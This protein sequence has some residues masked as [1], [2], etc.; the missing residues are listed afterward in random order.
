MNAGAGEPTPLGVAIGPE[1]ANV[2]VYSAHA[3]AIEFCLFGEAGDAEIARVRLP[4]RSGDIHHGFIPGVKAGALYGLR[5]YGA[6]AP[7]DGQRFDPAKL[8]ADPYA[9]ALDRPFKL[10]GAMF[11]RAADSAAFMPKCVAGAPSSAA[12]GRLNIPWGQTILYE[13]N[14]RGF[15]R[16]HPDVPEAQRGTFAG[17][18]HP[19]VIDHLV[20]LGVTSVEIMPAHAFVDERH[21]PPLGLANAWGYNPIVLGAPDP[22]LAPG[23]WREV[24][25]TTDALHAAGLEAILDVVLN[26]SGESDEFGPTLSM[27]GLDNAAYYRLLPGDPA[28][29]VNDTGCGNCLAL[30]REPML[31]LSIE[32]LRRWMIIGGFDGFRFDLATSIGRRDS[33]FDP[34]APLF[35]AIKRDDVLGAAKLIAEPWDIGP[36]G[37]RL[38][39]F[40]EGW[41]EWNDRFRDAARRFWRGDPYVRGEIA[42][43]IAGS[44]DIFPHAPGPTNSVNFVVA[45]D[46]F[47]LADLVSYEQKHNEANGENNRD[48]SNDNHSWNEGVEGPSEDPA[49][50]AA[51]ARDMR[52]LLS[53]LF[54][55][56]GA[57]MLPM[58]AELGYSQD[59]NNNAYAQNNAISWIDWPKADAALIEYTQRL[60]AIRRDHPALSRDA[61]LSGEPFD[62]SGL[63]DVE[64]RDAEGPLRTAQQ[65]EEP[66]GRILVVVFAAPRPGGEI[67]RVAIVLNRGH[68]GAAVALPSPRQGMAWRVLLDSTSP[69]QDVAANT[70]LACPP[71]ATLILAESV[72]PQAR[73]PKAASDPAIV[74]KLANAAG[75]AKEWWAIDG[76]RTQVNRETKIALLAAFRLPASSDAVARESLG[77]LVE[78]RER[79]PL[80]FYLVA[81]EGEVPV[82][83]LRNDPASLGVGEVTLRYEDGR[84]TAIKPDAETRRLALSDGREIVERRLP[85]P[86]LPLGRHVLIAGETT[87]DLTIAP[88]KAYLPEIARRRAFG[89]SAQLY[90][91]RRVGDQG[92]GDFSTLARLGAAAGAAGAATLGVNPLHMLFAQN[93]ERASPYHPSDRRFLDPIH[94]DALDGASLPSDADFVERALEKAREIAEVST[95]QTIDYPRVWGLK[96]LLLE[97]R[98]AAFQKTRRAQPSDPLFA[99]YDRYVAAGGE[100]LRR[101]ACFQAII[102]G[103]SRGDWREWPRDLRDGAPAAM[104]VIADRL[105]DRVEYAMFLQW[106]ADRQFAGAAARAKAGGLRLG[107]YRDLAIGAAPDGAEAWAGA[108]ELADGVSIGAPPDPFSRDGQIWHLPA[109][110]PLASARDGWR[111]FAGLFA[112]NM[113]HAGL[114]RI[115]HAM[116]L[117]RLFLVPKGAKPA[118]GAYVVY[119][120]RD[121]IG[122]LALESQR[123]QCV[124]VGEDLGTVP[125]GFRDTLAAADVLGMRVVWFEYDKGAFR[126]PQTYPA[127]AVACV[128]THDLPTLAGWW[129]GADI[130]ER[131]ALN[132]IDANSEKRER[133]ARAEEKGALVAALV[134]AGLIA[135]PPEPDAPAPGAL[136]A[137]IHAFVASAPSLLALAQIDDLAGETIATNLPGTDKER[138]NWRRRLPGDI[139]ALFTSARARAIISALAS[140]RPQPDF[141]AR[142]SA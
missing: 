47:T 140:L 82:A 37:Y 31:R 68:D 80:P 1:G 74:D 2:A 111:G 63:A 133:K 62:A 77:R 24:R 103:P 23:G 65:W 30:D 40:P 88:R 100:V 64:W 71:R 58:G 54:V 115:D 123:R 117:T 18:A 21:L 57:P 42:T 32:S 9:F 107:L 4:A 128:S 29:Y 121:L 39:D 22:R 36:G 19:K 11:E 127:L 122:I 27:R 72:A 44:R 96:S 110:D 3:E 135:A 141:G 139:D 83:P 134:A 52:N 76:A 112:A 46:G 84:E 113:R 35:A 41:S 91:Q 8:L 16:L 137:A 101:F 67:D 10:N 129:S 69:S 70:K 119:P 136:A 56:R 95:A 104:R 38:G 116:G 120:L 13:L 20:R 86:A 28:H 6:F 45:H 114:L 90:A 87:C 26:H 92:V 125:E 51:R 102:E 79:R 97:A 75:I 66:E 85:L 12:R 50:K 126:P 89:L 55:S 106:L 53:L 43:R 61:F 138:P 108:G 124:V 48:G 109:P 142:P 98:F 131:K 49:I 60:I 25:Q 34:A 118:E 5:A 14:L 17:L 132:L 81:R 73:K 15:T 94:I 59:G 130:A 99:E 33:G 78:E 105:R 7:E 93:R